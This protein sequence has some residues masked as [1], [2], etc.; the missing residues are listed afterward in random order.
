MVQAKKPLIVCALLDE[1]ENPKRRVLYTGMGKIKAITALSRVNRFSYDLV[2]NLGSCGSDNVSR[3]TLVRI[4]SHFEWDRQIPDGFEHQSHIIREHPLMKD[5]HPTKIP[6]ATCATGDSFV[7]NGIKGIPL[8]EDKP[9]VYDMEAYA[10][11]YWCAAMKKPFLCFKYV[12]DGGSQEEWLESLK[13]MHGIFDGV[14]DA[15]GI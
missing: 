11:A 12:S 15:I 6:T 13:K 2:I 1:Y 14:L 8:P 5:N 3:E 4:D 10:L 7:E 9:L